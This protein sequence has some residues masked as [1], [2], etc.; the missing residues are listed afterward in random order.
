MTLT[1][2]VNPQL[3]PTMNL[4]L[5]EV[6]FRSAQPSRQGFLMIWRNAPS[7]VIGRFQNAAAEVNLPFIR[8]HNLPI[9]RRISG[10]GAVY[11]DEGNINYS[12]IVPQEGPRFF[13]LKGVA[14]PLAFC[15]RN[16]GLNVTLTDRND[17]T[18]GGLKFSGCA[19]HVSSDMM[20]YHGT[21]LYNSHLPNLRE[22]LKS[23]EHRYR[24]KAVTSIRS[25]VVNITERLSNPPTVETFIEKLRRSTAHS[26]GVSET[27]Q[28]TE[29]ELHQAQELAQQRYQ[30][31][32]WNW[33]AS[34]DFT[35]TL[36]WKSFSV[37]L[38]V[39]D[40]IISSVNFQGEKN[41][42]TTVEK[43]LTG[44]RYPFENLPDIDA[45][46]SSDELE[47]WLMQ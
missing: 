22:A 24:S 45:P 4:A 20:L 9:L 33:G 47:Q 6:L 3:D 7:V 30:S 5:E 15:L 36:P 8:R 28:A 44:L 42:S 32:Q 14:E 10:G 37:E 18:T 11:H 1:A 27:R 17:M 26:C 16:L 19:Q 35:V 23:D 13:H 41:M 21:L 46:L 43:A 39:I 2:I 38:H 29:E 34:P 25:S 31:W 40:G 12:F